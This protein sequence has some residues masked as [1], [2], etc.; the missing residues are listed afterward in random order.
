MKTNK[1]RFIVFLLM[2]S[3]VAV[4]CG[5]DAAEETS[6]APETTEAPQET[7]A[8]PATT[9]PPPEKLVIW[10]EEKIAIALD[11]LVGA[12]ES[13]AGVDV[14]VVIYDFGAIKNDVLTA[15]P[16]G[17]GPDLF[18]GP[19]DMVGEIVANGVVAPLDLGSIASDIFDV[20][21]TAFSYGGDVYGFPY[22]TEAIA[23]YYNADLVDG[24]PTT[25]EE[26][27]AACDAAGTE[28][29]VGAPGGGGGGDAYHC[30]LYTS[31]SPRDVP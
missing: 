16:A 14:E 6:E 10:A 7:L 22:A 11:P 5:G 3:M 12:Y 25:W 15:G 29:C 28:L 4:A 30:L 18:V 19:H 23:M 26:V 13:A 31:P 21:V 8:A 27:K 24:V 1:L 2:F 20:G 9:A 17:E